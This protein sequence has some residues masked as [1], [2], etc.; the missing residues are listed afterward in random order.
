LNSGHGRGIKHLKVSKPVLIA[1]IL[2]ILFAA[3]TLLFTGKKR[4]ASLSSPVA[5]L[6]ETSPQI[7]HPATVGEI[8]KLDLRTMNLAWQNDPF[9][10]PKS[11]MDKK[12]EKQKVVLKLVAIMDSKAGRYAIIGGEI[13]KKGDK[14]G[15]EKVAEIERDK[16]VLIRNNAKR[17]LSIEDAGQ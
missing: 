5:K 7:S 2:A 16:V 13:V 3:Y 14:I 6:T 9:S 1:L 10:L 15:D 17:I 4:P 11:V 8:P 12:T